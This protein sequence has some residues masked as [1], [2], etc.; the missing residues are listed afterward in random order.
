MWLRE[1]LC[2]AEGEGAVADVGRMKTLPEKG[3]REREK[4]HSF[5][6]LLKDVH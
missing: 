6:D 2:G 4:D 5:S 1:G 3:G